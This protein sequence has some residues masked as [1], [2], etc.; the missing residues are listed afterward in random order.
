M[1]QTHFQ[2]SEIRQNW[3]C[4][5]FFTPNFGCITCCETI[6]FKFVP[7]SLFLKMFSESNVSTFEITSSA[8]QV[9]N[10]LHWLKIR[11]KKQNAKL[12]CINFA[13]FK[14]LHTQN[15]EPHHEQDWVIILSPKGFAKWFHCGS[16]CTLSDTHILNNKIL[17]LMTIIPTLFSLPQDC[18]YQ[19][20][21]FSL[22]SL[23]TPH[24]QFFVI[25][26]H[27]ASKSRIASQTCIP[28]MCFR[29]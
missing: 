3:F 21:V 11:C 19:S 29:F 7:H 6:R 23:L 1:P 18:M 28:D 20:C 15:F 16:H 5:L 22:C 27:L 13:P 8:N 4:I 12:C 10:Q 9:L 14:V 24:L 26:W 17:C 2:T 25:G